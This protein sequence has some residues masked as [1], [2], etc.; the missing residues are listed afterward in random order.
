MEDVVESLTRGNVTEVKVL[1][2][3]VALA[4]ALYQLVLIAV[5]YGKLRTGVV[6]AAPAGM[7]HRASGDTIALLLVIVGVMCAPG[8]DL[9]TSAGD[10]EREERL[11]DGG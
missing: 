3:S 7:A 8:R 11:E 5:V 2:A 1:V 9:A 10:E 6:E 4:L